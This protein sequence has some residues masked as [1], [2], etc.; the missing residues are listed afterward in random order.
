MKDVQERKG[1][2]HSK[3]VMLEV[4]LDSEVKGRG[5][6]QK[7]L[8]PI[9]GSVWSEQ[10]KQPSFT[11]RDDTSPGGQNLDFSSKQAPGSRVSPQPQECENQ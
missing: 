6:D 5:I 8:L 7:H 3:V 10:K 2:L 4:N 9:S 1:K 11:C